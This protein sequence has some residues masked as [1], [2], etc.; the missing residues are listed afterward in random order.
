MAMA[1][2]WVD[3]AAAAGAIAAAAEVPE[4]TGADAGADTDAD[5]DVSSCK[6]V[7]AW[8]VRPFRTSTSLMNALNAAEESG[9]L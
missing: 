3:P 8:S 1:V 5:V 7:N 9:W 2:S 6:R 4:G